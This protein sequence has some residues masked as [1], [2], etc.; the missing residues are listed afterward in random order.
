V[1]HRLS[2]KT[3][4]LPLATP[5]RTARGLWETRDGLLVRLEDELGRV[6]Y[7]EAAPVPWFGTETLAEAEASCRALGENVTDEFLDAV[8]ARLGCVRFA[9]AAARNRDD[10]PAGDRRLPVATLL[11]AGREALEALPARL[12]TGFMAFKWKVGVGELNDELAI[13]DDLLALLP[14]YTRLRLDANG[15]WTRRMAMRWCERCAERPVEFI[16]QPLP[17]DDEDGLRGLAADYPV[18]VALDESAVHLG[19]IRRWCGQG[20]MGV[21]VVK[22]A[23]AGP[24]AELRRLIEE[25]KLDVVLSSAIET[26]VGRQAVLREA[27]RGGLTHRALGFGVGA[28]LGRPEFDGPHLGPLLDRSWVDTANP[29]AAWNALS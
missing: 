3:Y 27:L 11:P 19:D 26:V 18:K 1:F 6:G 16:E 10:A 2:C 23:L 21:F 22:P 25:L 29:E 14:H 24:L 12:E 7:G 28:V 8:P 4:R 9:L 15:A 13:L 20:W 5:L 17:P